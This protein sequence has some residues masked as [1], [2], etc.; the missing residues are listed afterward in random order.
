MITHYLAVDGGGT[1]TAI[2]L[3][4]ACHNGAEHV[5]TLTT[6][7]SSLTQQGKQGIQTIVSGVQQMLRQ[8]QL[9]PAQCMLVAG[10]AGA[11]HSELKQQLD[12]A[13]SSFPNRLVTT[14]AHISLAG[15]AN[16]N[17]VNCIAIGTGTV[18]T[19]L[20]PDNSVALI[21]GWGFPI[22]DQGGGAWLG[23]EAVRA[24]IHSIDVGQSNTLADVIRLTV[25]SHR[26]EVLNWVKTANA[27][28]YAQLAPAV[29]DSANQGCVVAQTIIR[30][31]VEHIESLVK[32]CCE[33]NELAIVFLGSLGQYY[34]PKLANQ[35]QTRCIVPQ[36]TALD[37]ATLLASQLSGE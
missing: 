4:L 23:F 30:R 1:K 21:G 11:S 5:S 37:G 17:A 33:N 8:H 36:G 14:D 24:L 19:R 9:S 35:W 27:T 32:D 12:S 6:G 22:G 16:G 29:S 18:A 10:V 31:G 25:G 13:L 15:A 2:Q 26:L 34:Q 3:T 20:N 7:P 28:R